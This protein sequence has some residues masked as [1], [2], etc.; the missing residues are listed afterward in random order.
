M[1]KNQYILLLSYLMLA[2]FVQ[3]QENA[4]DQENFI[5]QEEPME[6]SASEHAIIFMTQE[7]D[8]PEG[9]YYPA[10]HIIILD[11]DNKQPINSASAYIGDDS[12]S[13]IIEQKNIIPHEEPHYLGYFINDNDETIYLYGIKDKIIPNDATAQED[14]EYEDE[15]DEN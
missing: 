3:T 2:T 1:K 8:Y 6:K 11:H 13:E 9:E 4:P 10:Q 5:A 15:T 7:E 14:D 12:Y